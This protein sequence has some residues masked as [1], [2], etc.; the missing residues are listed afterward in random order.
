MNRRRHGA[1]LFLGGWAMVLGVVG[2]IGCKSEVPDRDAPG[3]ILSGSEYQNLMARNAGRDAGALV[4]PAK[5]AVIVPTTMRAAPTTASAPS[6][7]AAPPAA[8]T[9]AAP[10]APASPA[11][12]A[13]A[14]TAPPAPAPEPAPAPTTG[15]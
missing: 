9:P 5:P 11:A 3:G 10:A 12:P 2:V 14:G 15:K 8:A 4:E 13:D 6:A 7:P 1:V